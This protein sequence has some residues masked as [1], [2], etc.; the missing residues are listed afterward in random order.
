[1]RAAWPAGV[2]FPTEPALCLETGALLAAGQAA[3]G[4]TQYEQHPGQCTTHARRH[5]SGTGIFFLVN[6]SQ[7]LLVRDSQATYATHHIYVD[8]HG[9]PDVGVRRGAPLHLHAEN[10][11]KLGKMAATDRVGLEVAVLRSTQDRVLRES[12]Y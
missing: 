6:R 4:T 5:G 10:Y 7:V 2:E 12:Y 9:E 1:M 8:A 11:R 3:R